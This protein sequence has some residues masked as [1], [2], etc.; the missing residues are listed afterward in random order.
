MGRVKGRT[1]HQGSGVF[2]ERPNVGDRTENGTVVV[3]ALG[4]AS[5]GE[6]RAE[7]DGGSTHSGSDGSTKMIIRKEVE[8]SVSVGHS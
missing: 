4:P 2:R 6:G 3:E 5:S 7:G 8:Y 1:G